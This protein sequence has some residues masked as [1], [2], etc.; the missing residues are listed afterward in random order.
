MDFDYVAFL[1]SDDWWAPTFLKEI[2]KA[3]TNYPN[4]RIFAT[5]RS[6]VFL[7]E[8]ERYSHELLPNNGDT[9]IISYFKVINKFLPLINSSNSV[10]KKT[11]TISSA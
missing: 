10:F 8:T 4:N 1:D 7:E 6:R 3:I 5:G 11:S 2:V 9:E